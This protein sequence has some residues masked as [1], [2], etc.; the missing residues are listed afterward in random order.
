MH[1]N[2]K[3]SVQFIFLKIGQH[4]QIQHK[5][6]VGGRGH[7]RHIY[8]YKTYIYAAPRFVIYNTEKK[9]GYKNQIQ[10]TRSTCTF[11]VN[12]PPSPPPSTPFS[13]HKEH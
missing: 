12:L 10:S 7:T 9:A 8:A 11:E 2:S 5:K 4:V 6:L 1:A 3:N 13:P